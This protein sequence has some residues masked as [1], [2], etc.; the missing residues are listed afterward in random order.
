MLNN[1]TVKYLRLTVSYADTQVGLANGIGA[2]PAGVTY[3]IIDAD[4]SGQTVTAEGVYSG[5]DLTAQGVVKLVNSQLFG[6]FLLPVGA[7][8]LNLGLYDANNNLLKAWTVVDGGSPTLNFTANHF[9]SLGRKVS[10]GDTTGGGTPDT[11]DDD[12]A[13]DLL[14]D[15]VIVLSIDPSWNTI[16][17]LVIQ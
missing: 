10:K 6:K 17:N 8:T 13:I 14:K 16:H 12:S 3:N 11:G 15:Q 9:Y 7:V 2:A 4:L 5:N 1:T